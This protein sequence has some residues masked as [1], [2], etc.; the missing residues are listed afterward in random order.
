[1]E[2]ALWPVSTQEWGKMH[3]YKQ[4]YAK[5]SVKK[6]GHC[7]LVAI[8]IVLWVLGQNSLYLPR[9]LVH[10]TTFKN[11]GCTAFSLDTKKVQGVFVS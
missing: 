9:W 10:I 3:L 8:I 11:D 5:E 2:S 4:N 1:M 7:W 6:G